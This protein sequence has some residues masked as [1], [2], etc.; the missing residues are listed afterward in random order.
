MER[1]IRRGL[2]E[3]FRIFPGITSFPLAEGTHCKVYQL[4][5]KCQEEA[6]AGDMAFGWNWKCG[7]LPR[8]TFL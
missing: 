7:I 3:R 6:T 1:F 8:K 4:R 2:G 5:R